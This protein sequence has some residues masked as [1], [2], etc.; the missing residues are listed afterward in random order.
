MLLLPLSEVLDAVE[1]EAVST[2]RQ[3]CMQVITED[4]NYRFAAADEDDLAKWLGSLKSVLAKRKK[5]N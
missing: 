1:T 2:R 5:E 3:Y 4:M